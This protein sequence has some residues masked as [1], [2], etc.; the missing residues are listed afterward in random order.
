VGST[1]SVWPA[2]DVVMR[3]ANRGLPIVVVNRGE[4]DV[5]H[6]AMVRIDSSIGEVLPGI[7]DRLLA[8]P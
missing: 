7:V 2:A 6:L 4:T 3:A 1:V 8:R 5:D